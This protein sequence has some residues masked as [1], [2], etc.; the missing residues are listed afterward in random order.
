MLSI[1]TLKN[2]K[3]LALHKSIKDGLLKNYPAMNNK[4]MR[5]FKYFQSKDFTYF[6]KSTTK[7]AHFM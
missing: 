7:N 5:I 2:F 6:T 4:E 1:I 3:F